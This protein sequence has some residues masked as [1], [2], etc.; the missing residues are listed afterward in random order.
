MLTLLN[1]LAGIEMHPYSFTE[2][3]KEDR[4]FE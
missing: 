3:D 4:I 1:I 2:A